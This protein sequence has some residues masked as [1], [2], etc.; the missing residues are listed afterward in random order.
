MSNPSLWW[1]KPLVI[2]PH[3]FDYKTAAERD[4]AALERLVRWK[5]KAGFDA[6]HLMLNFSMFEGQGG[7]DSRAYYFKNFHGCREDWLSQYLPVAHHHGLRVIIY[8]NCH[9]FKPD[10]FPADHYVVAPDGKPKVIYGDGGEIC[11][12]G[13]F[14]AWSEKMA[15]DLGRYPIDGVFLD[16]PVKDSC[17]CPHCRAAFQARQGEELPV[18]PAAC[19]PPLQAAYED[20]IA[21][22]PVAYIEAFARG[23]RRHNPDAVLYCNGGDSRQMKASLPCTQLVGEEGGFIGYGPL[24]GEFPFNAGLAAKRME[25][26]ARG[27]ARVIFCD[28]GYK[29]YDYYIHPKGEIAR[30]YAGTLAN[31][32]N[33]WIGV[34][35]SAAKAPGIQTVYRFNRLVREYREALANGE[36]LAEAALLDSPLNL[37]LAGM[38]Q[39]ASGD[40][41]HKREAA[42]QRLAVP[43][44][45]QEFNGLYAAFT[46]SGYPF[47]V[48]EEDTLLED[49]L[50]P[51]IKLLVL[52]GVSAVSDAFVERVRRFVADGGRLLATFDTS[53]FD[54]RGM[55]RRDFALADV[56]GAGAAGDLQGPS[57]LDY[58]GIKRGNA[59]TVGLR[60]NLLP[61]P[62]YWRLVKPAASATALL[63]YYEKMPRRYAALPPL[64]RHPAA[65]FNRCGKGAAIFIPSAIGDLSLRYRFPAIRVLLR[66]AARL[67]APPPVVMEGGD[68]FVEATL[69]RAADGSVVLHLINWASGERPSAGAIPLGPLRVR[70]RLPRGANRPRSVQ[71]AFA[72]RKAKV[73]AKGRYANF[74]IPRI[75]EYEMA[76]MI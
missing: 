72:G 8:F 53:L 62:E 16:G 22:V 23:L 6:E 28:C 11:C 34:N 45:S 41:V 7:E 52:P 48:V 4:P 39:A 64:S 10:T 15:E 61:C 37:T 42:A 75:E 50:P 30:M 70:V 1:Q 33:A 57:G 58:L 24:T 19:P 54:E 21:E 2:L 67:L 38:V 13:P 46:R 32:A 25:C 55:R 65:L 69:R 71:L 73:T 26:R 63:D 76:I 49:R 20:F 60:Q 5:R 56:F 3:G 59:L 66:N 9:W 40:D 74:V 43:R 18:N 29:V 47:D 14:Q 12:R 35:R 44:H 17:W 36:S 27:R 31:G 68:E 51:R